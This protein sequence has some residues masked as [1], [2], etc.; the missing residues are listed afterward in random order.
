MIIEMRTY[1]TR[2]GIREELLSVF[3]TKSMPAHR[4]IGMKIMGPLL[5]IEDADVFFSC[6]RFPDL[7]SRGPM[8]DRFLRRDT[9]L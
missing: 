9:F 5:S 2:P 7:E 1:K 4:D 8:R 3:E 6:E